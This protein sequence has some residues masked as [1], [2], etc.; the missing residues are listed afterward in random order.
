MP[1]CLWLK[2]VW[3]SFEVNIWGWMAFRSTGCGHSIL[4]DCCWIMNM[5]C[6]MTKDSYQTQ[7]DK[8][9]K[10]VA[11]TFQCYGEI[12]VD[13]CG[14]LAPSF[15]I[16]LLPYHLEAKPF[17]CRLWYRTFHE[18]PAVENIFICVSSAFGH[19]CAFQLSVRTMRTV[20]KGFRCHIPW[21][22]A[23]FRKKHWNSNGRHRPAFE[24]NISILFLL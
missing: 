4:Q 18:L 13:Y 23:N 21:L 8:L 1:A 11:A 20:F 22:S 5:P 24:W 17:I 2:D 7:Q 15:M 14:I 9:E 12:G 10:S 16:L 3:D 19:K 6:S